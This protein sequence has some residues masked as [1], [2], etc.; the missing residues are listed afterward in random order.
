MELTGFNLFKVSESGSPVKKILAAAAVTFAI[1]SPLAAPIPVFGATYSGSLTSVQSASVAEGKEN[2]V[3]VTFNDNV[4]GKIT[5]LEDGIFRYNVDPTGKFSEYAV[6]R[7]RD[8]VGRIPAQPDASPLYK[9]PRATVTET[10][11]AFEIK[12]GDVTVVLDKATA[13]LS[14][15]KGS[16]TVLREVAPLAIGNKTVQKLEKASG[17]NYFGGGTQNGRFIHTGEAIEIITNNTY[18]DGG[19]SSPNPFY[20]SSGGYGV[21]RNTFSQGT[22]DFGKSNGDEVAASHNEAEF[23]AYY[24]VTDKTTPREVAQELLREYYKVTGNPVLLPEYAFY[25]GHYNAYN[26]DMWSDTALPGYRKWEIKGHGAASAADVNEKVTY[27]KGGTGTAMQENSLVETLNGTGPTVSTDKIPNGVTFSEKFSARNRVDEYLSR[28]MSLGYFLPNDGYGAGYGQNGYNMTGGVN[29]D[30]TSSPER[31][32]AIAANVDNLRQFSEYINPKG[33]HTGLWTQSSLLPNSNPATFWQLLRDFENEVKKGNV[34][35]LKTDVAWVGSGYSFGL[36]GTKQAYDIVTTSK[37]NTGTRP[38]I[39]TLDGWAGSQRYVGIWSGDQVGG[40]WEYIRFHIPTFIGQSLSGNPN[41]GSDMDGIWGGH[42]II[43]TRDYQFKTFAPLMLDMDGWGTY[44]KMPYTHGD[45]YTGI[46]R[47]YLKLKSTLLPYIYTTAAS[48]ANI[49]TGNNDTGLPFVRA[50]LLSENSNYALSKATQ[51]EYTMGGNILVAPVYQNTDGDSANGG[52]GDGNDVRNGIYLPGDEN[53]IWTDYFTGKQYRGGQ[54]LNNFD[55]PIWKLPVFVKGNSIIPMWEPSM[56]PQ[57]IDRSKRIV[58][59]FATNGKGEYTS[60]ED[61]GTFIENNI[62]TSDAEYG[63]QE[64]ISYGEHVSTHFTSSV[65]GDEATFTA[66]ASTG[67]Y[68]G[69]NS[70]RTSTFVV[71]VSAEPTGVVAKNGDAALTI[72]KVSSEAEF[73]AATPAEGE[74]VYFYNAAPNLNY[75]ATAADEAV[76]NEGFSATAITTTPKLM[77]KFAKTD[78][79]TTVQTLTVSGFKNDGKLPVMGLNESLAV[80]TNLAAAEETKTPTSIALTWT[81]VEGA[82]DYEVEADGVVFNMGDVDSY[83][84]QHLPYNSTHTYRIRSRNKDGFSQWSDSITTASLQDPWRNV[85]KPVANDWKLGDSWGA[86]KNA[87]DHNKGQMFHSTNGNTVGVPL[88]LDYGKAYQLDKFVYTPRQDNAGNGNIK[89]MKVETSLDGVHWQEH[90]AG[91]WD[92]TGAGK[93]DDKTVDLTGIIA[94][95]L[96]L[97]NLESAGGFFSAGELALFKKDGSR[98]FEVGSV[99]YGATVGDTDYQHLKGNMLG[100]ENRAPMVEEWNTHVKSHAADFN[101]NGAYDVYDMAFTMSKLD[102]GTTKNGAIAGTLV[103]VVSKQQVSAG[104]V[105]TVDLYGTNIKNANALGALL[106]YDGSKFELVE[107]SIKQDMS[108]AGMENLSVAQ[109]GFNDG[110]QSVNLAFANHGDKALYSG[111]GV[112]ASF[113]LKA[114]QDSAVD[115]TTTTWL[116]GPKC[117]AIENKIA[118][119]V[120]FPEAPQSARAEYPMDAFNTSITN[121]VLTTDD[122]SN[123]A[124]ML[125]DPAGFA[126]LFDNNETANGFEYKWDWQNNYLDGAQELPNYVKLPSTLHFAFKQPS[127]LD[128]VEVVNRPSGNGTMQSMRAVI[129]FEDGTQQE[130]AGGAFDSMQAKYTLQVSEDNKDKKAT[131]VE[132]TPL[133]STGTAKGSNPSN[134]MLTLREINFNYMTPTPKVESIALGEHPSSLYEGDLAPVK[135]DVR[136]PDDVYPYY[137]VESSNP[138]I[139]SIS[140]VQNGDNVDYYVRGNAAGTVTITAKSKLDESKTVSYEL[141][142]KAGVDTTGLVAAI[143]MANS[144][145]ASVYTKASMEKLTKA[146]ADAQAV[147]K[148]ENPTKA[149]VQA[150]Q[151]ALEKALSELVMRPVK[152]ENLINKDAQSS[153]AQ[154]AASSTATE[155]LTPEGAVG[156]TLDQDPTTIWHSNYNAPHRGMPQWLVYDLGEERDLTDVTF[157]PRQDSGTNGDI[158]SVEV[159]VANTPQAFGLAAANEAVPAS[160]SA[161]RSAAEAETPRSLGVF[162]F[163]NDG[164]VLKD[165]TEW[166]QMSF[167]ATRARYVKLNILHAG[168]SEADQYASLAETRFYARPP[169]TPAEKADLE[170]LINKIDGEHLEAEGYTDAT[171]TPFANAL[172]DAKRIL[173]DDEASQDE[174]DAAR[175]ALTSARAKLAQTVAPSVEHADKTALKALVDKVKDSDLTGKTP[176]SVRAFENALAYAKQVLADENASEA[177]IQAA[178]SQLRSAAD[179]LTNVAA[180]GDAGNS[181]TESGGTSGGVTDVP[182]TTTPNTSDSST[183]TPPSNNGGSESENASENQG[184]SGNNGGAG[185]MGNNGGTGNGV[186]NIPGTTKPNT[187]DSSTGRAPHSDGKQKLVAT[188]DSTMGVVVASAAAGTALVAGA[189]YKRRRNEKTDA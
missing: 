77:V 20:W 145:H 150:A 131:K 165:R 1:A 54:V 74:A 124:K 60:F 101:L 136:T 107:D 141:E 180:P 76:R 170:T 148:K 55:A 98:A 104:E 115:L 171:W 99:T 97:T 168:G 147:L 78:V 143:N 182:G 45:P 138:A 84:H 160:R 17:E 6:P 9:K 181:G 26:R 16:K 159:L 12:A 125:Q 56:N 75:N 103:P 53:T 32:A 7:S 3:N 63:K 169:M 41:A 70:N 184:G 57:N 4:P 94:R 175:D 59:F 2:V 118:E 166:K 144:K 139:A 185:A 11:T 114:K 33:V 37:G 88:T 21:V 135:A 13:K 113:K 85:P 81:K 158:F 174:V 167:G 50:I 152:D 58:E 108:I 116:V 153:V 129:H 93:F 140:A 8:H 134:R 35:T 36:N 40:N 71:N 137:T 146:V 110:K 127:V 102:G 121:D 92:N 132:I 80:P 91:V 142:V 65:N 69:Y 130:F 44:A 31:L 90:D 46:N 28:D 14:V 62:D 38:N 163:D 172:A 29:P 5:F 95:Y 161:F 27:E 24:M 42:P 34:S 82:T 128:N 64:K 149:N 47:M 61:T 189:L 30:G 39:V 49:D 73:K 18:V 157:L 123:A 122:G 79:K 22:Y 120:S 156:S 87:F 106:H 178:F 164:R 109:G 173:A 151:L 187:T 51:Y 119:A 15:K 154:M 155:N 162:N 133:T 89:R 66:E 126:A 105:V 83:N 52:L 25:L 176:D 67:N 188:G 179:G 186:T 183:G 48:A 72:K 43:A 96:R 23:D 86:F 111:S 112:V 177:S 10:A 100:R 117:D 68:E 19:V